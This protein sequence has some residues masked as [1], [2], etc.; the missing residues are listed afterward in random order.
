[1][2]IELNK[3]NGVEQDSPPDLMAEVNKLER[4]HAAGKKSGKRQATVIDIGVLPGKAQP[5][6]PPPPVAEEDPDLAIMR[7]MQATMPEAAAKA[8]QQAA[9][10]EARRPESDEYFRVSPDPAHRTIVWLLERK[11]HVRSEDEEHY[12]QVD[13][14]M[15]GKFLG[16]KSKVTRY[17][18]RHAINKMGVAWILPVPLD[19]SLGHAKGVRAYVE[20]AETTWIKVFTS[21]SK[22]DWEA[23]GNQDLSPEY[24]ASFPR[25]VVSAFG[26]GRIQSEDHPI[27]KAVCGE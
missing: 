21:K 19:S 11:F 26:E 25:M 3:G 20:K 5:A 2:P 4:E 13:E 10:Y 14:T 9:S 1:M 23:A 16:H 6:P 17:E 24:T 15:V 7:S 8:M 12:Y 18:L 22:V 27:Y